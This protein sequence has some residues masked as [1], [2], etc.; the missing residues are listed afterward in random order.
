MVEKLSCRRD[1]KAAAALGLLLQRA[2]CECCLTSGTS[3]LPNTCHSGKVVS[4]RN[5]EAGKGLLGEGGG[6]TQPLQGLECGSSAPSVNLSS[7][8][9]KLACHSRGAPSG[10]RGMECPLNRN[11]A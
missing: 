8:G 3:P 4:T 11:S 7:S 1:G 10:V 5:D 2:P 6:G 9:R